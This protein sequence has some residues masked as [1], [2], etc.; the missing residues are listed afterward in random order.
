MR[1]PRNKNTLFLYRY[2]KHNANA[3]TTKNCPIEMDQRNGMRE[4][5]STKLWTHKSNIYPNKNKRFHGIG[6]ATGRHTGK[7]RLYAI[8]A[9]RQHT[10][11]A[12]Q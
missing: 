6:T 12:H 4:K 5:S 2:S 9:L 3:T 1:S 10:H 11:L 8:F 7:F